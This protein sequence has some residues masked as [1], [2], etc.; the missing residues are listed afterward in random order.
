M[1]GV[2]PGGVEARMLNRFVIPPL[3]GGRLPQAG[4]GAHVH[5]PAGDALFSSINCSWPLS[6]VRETVLYE[7]DCRASWVYENPWEAQLL[8]TCEK[9]EGK[10]SS[11]FGESNQTTFGSSGWCCVKSEENLEQR[12]TTDPPQKSWPPAPAT[13]LLP[14]RAAISRLVPR[15]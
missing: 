12:N 11:T 15:L 13:Q 2:E 8:A 4:I 6:L 10:D 5:P 14:P 3:L 1:A 7:N 9:G